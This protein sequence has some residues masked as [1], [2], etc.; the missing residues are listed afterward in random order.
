MWFGAEA[1]SASMQW[2]TWFGA[3]VV[4]ASSGARGLVLRLLVRVVW[5]VVW[6]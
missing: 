1:A 6:C 4:S 2:G 3:E 5:D